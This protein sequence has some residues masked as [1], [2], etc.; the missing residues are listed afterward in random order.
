MT[1]VTL[2]K[3]ITESISDTIDM[4]LVNEFG[5]T[6]NFFS[7]YTIFTKELLLKNEIEETLREMEYDLQAII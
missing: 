5:L 4:P 7:F 1:T 3:L 2:K 6:N